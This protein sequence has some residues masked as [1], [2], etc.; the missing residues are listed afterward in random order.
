MKSEGAT[1]PKATITRHTC[2]VTPSRRA[3]LQPCKCTIGICG[4]GIAL[5]TTLKF[6]RIGGHV[7]RRI[8]HRH[9]IPFEIIG[10]PLL[11]NVSLPSQSIGDIAVMASIS[12]N[13]RAER[14]IAIAVPAERITTLHCIAAL[15]PIGQY[16]YKE[17]CEGDSNSLESHYFYSIVGRSHNPI[18]QFPHTDNGTGK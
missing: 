14:S 9:R 13:I 16:G 6:P 12:D 18:I 4:G 5:A 17:N 15:C 3:L 8:R 7:E 1:E 2:L 10:K 11:D